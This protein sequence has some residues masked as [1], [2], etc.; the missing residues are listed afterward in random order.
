MRLHHHLLLPLSPS[1][2]AAVGGTLPVIPGGDAEG[3]VPTV[4]LGGVPL[5]G[6]QQYGGVGALPQQQEQ[7]HPLRHHYRT[8]QRTFSH[9]QLVEG[10]RGHRRAA[11]KTDFILPAGHEEREKEGAGGGGAGA[12]GTGGTSSSYSKGHRREASRTESVYTIR[13]HKRT[14]LQKLMFWKKV[15]WRGE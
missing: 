6:Q 7:Q 15:C 3:V 12:M 2:S 5:V 13:Q 1:G 10:G 8:H 9:G 14:M 4:A 11:S